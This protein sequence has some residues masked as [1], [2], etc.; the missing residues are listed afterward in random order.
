MH[1]FNLQKIAAL[2]TNRQVYLRGVSCYNAGLVRDTER[3]TGGVYEEIF[4]SLKPDDFAAVGVFQ[5]DEDQLRENVELYNEW[6]AER[7]NKIS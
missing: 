3:Y 6:S 2:A 5:R 4:T 1:M 7:K